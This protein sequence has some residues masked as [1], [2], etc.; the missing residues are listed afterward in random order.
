MAIPDLNLR[1]AIAE[2]LGKENTAIVS[3]TAEEMATLTTLSTSDR[4]IKDLTGMEHAVNLEEMWIEDAHISNL[5]PL[6]G[7]RN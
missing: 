2:T 3:I 6:Q 7:S 5:A 1:T 4:D